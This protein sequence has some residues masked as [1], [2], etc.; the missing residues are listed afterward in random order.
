M[1]VDVPVAGTGR[2]GNYRELREVD[3]MFAATGAGRPAGRGCAED[4]RRRSGGCGAVWNSSRREIRR[5][6]GIRLRRTRG[7]AG[8]APL[9][10]GAIHAGDAAGGTDCATGD[11]GGADFTGDSVSEA[12]GGGAETVWAAEVAEAAVELVKGEKLERSVRVK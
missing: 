7:G 4:G 12:G 3:G 11:G 5:C 2:L 9:F 10:S 1:A 6:W 8:S